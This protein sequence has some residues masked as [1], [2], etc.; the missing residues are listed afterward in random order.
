MDFPYIIV[1]ISAAIV[2]A[3]WYYRNTVP[4]IY[5][6]KKWIIITL[7]VV[8][9]MVL[10]IGFAEPVISVVTT[11]T[12]H[13][14]TA[15]M[16]DTSLSMDIP[17][18]PARKRDALNTLNTTR[19]NIGNRG[20]FFTF[21]D[22]IQPMESGEPEFKGT[23]TDIYN[24]IQSAGAHRDVSSIILISDGRWN[25]GRNPITAGFPENIPV[26]TVMVGS[27]TMG[28]EVVLKRISAPPIGREGST[29]PIEIIAASSVKSPDPMKVEIL[30]NNR[31]V[32]EGTLTFG[33][34]T[35]AR[36]TFELPLEKPGNHEFIAA[37][38]PVKD[39]LSS[40]NSRIF[41]VNVLKNSFHVLLAA[42]RPSADLA[43]IRRVIESDPEF[44]LHMVIDQGMIS[45]P[46][47]TYPDDLSEFDALI[48]LDGGGLMITSSRAENLAQKV[49]QG[50]GLWLSGSTPL[51][52]EAF[53]LKKI[54]PV[55]FSK[56]DLPVNSDL[57]ISLTDI[58]RSHFVTSGE[59]GM[60]TEREWN[61]LPPVSAILPI[62]DVSGTGRVL[63]QASGKSARGNILPVIIT[64]KHGNG[65]I[66]ITPIS[67][68][69][70]W[71]LMMEGAGKGGEFFDTF[72]LGT[73]R[74]LTTEM[75]TSPLTV[76][77]DSQT[78][79]S[80]EEIMFEGR[81][82]DNVYMPVSGADINLIIDDNPVL[83]VFLKENGSSAYTGTIRGIE[84][85]KHVFNATAFVND[86]RF[87]ESSGTFLMENFS[88]ETID[89]TP[90]PEL[91]KIIAERTGG[92]NVTSAG[93]DSIFTLLTPHITT[94]RVEEDHHVYLNPIIPVI[95]IVFLVTE[96]IIRKRR[97]MI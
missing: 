81:L 54:L 73:L 51:K 57:H 68:I 56:S 23:A 65:K 82:F 55:S 39:T 36:I 34:G 88:L 92:I 69:W 13:D 48:L 37:I 87:A 10:I 42:A 7:R 28:E 32:M 35:Q 90:D 52:D 16:L 38:K 18:D 75:E 44:T 45:T 86:T 8:V 33:E 67:G 79:L 93:I 58:G 95:A 9:L 29:L 3:I 46:E 40:N 85:G 30:E 78:Y 66:L 22:R 19:S 2:I 14:V 94:E 1:L 97:G 84:P 62:S 61:V 26:H 21:N 47:N 31:T 80:G 64:G 83:K 49:S 96:W 74:W 89:A 25:L 70:H 11:F 4:P 6:W 71:R 27:R 43:F 12:R 59:R 24:A 41:H 63:A 60:N 76:T 5:G 53:I 15:V 50:G 77:T 17:Q 20:V 91:L 72:V